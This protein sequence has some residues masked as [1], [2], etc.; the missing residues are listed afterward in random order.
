MAEVQTFSAA[1]G[2]GEGARTQVAQQARLPHSKRFEPPCAS[3]LRK[4]LNA[5]YLGWLVLAVV[6][7]APIAG[8]AWA[9]PAIDVS[10]RDRLLRQAL[11]AYSAAM[12]T[13]DRDQRLQGFAL[14]EQ[15]FRQVA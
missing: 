12:N 2:W 4:C 14:A 5:S 6:A 3:Q 11:E 7:Y 1:Q 8:A 10:G 13:P 15:L 9:A